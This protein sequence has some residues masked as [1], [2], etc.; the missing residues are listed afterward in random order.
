VSCIGLPPNTDSINNLVDSKY[1]DENG[2]IKVDGYLRVQDMKNKK[3]FAIGDCCNTKED[4]MAAYAGAQAELLVNNITMTLRG[5]RM[6]ELKE[7]WRPFFGMLVPFGSRDGVGF[8]QN[9]MIVNFIGRFLKY[10]NLFTEKFWGLAGL[11]EPKVYP[12]K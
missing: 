9:F 8:Y 4:K 1:I 2:R 5:Y 11:D 6:E 10:G 12:K 3:I 7:Y